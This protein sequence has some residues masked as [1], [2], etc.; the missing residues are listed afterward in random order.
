MTMFAVIDRSGEAKNEGLELR[1]TKLVI[2]GC[3]TAGT[4]VIVAASLRH[5]IGRSRSSSGPTDSRRRPAKRAACAR[6][7]LQAKRRSGRQTGGIDTLTDAF[8]KG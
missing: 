2:F 7:P 4:P 8:I 5:S 6:C 1:D 3:P